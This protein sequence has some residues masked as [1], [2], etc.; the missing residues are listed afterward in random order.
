M[1]AIARAV[2]LPAR[3]LAT[4]VE[5][6]RISPEN[7]MAIAIAYG[8]HP[9]GALVDTGYLDEQWA[10][11]IDPVR[12]LRSVTEDQ[13]ADEVLRR[14]KLGQ[15]HDALD[16]PIDRLAER[17]ARKSNTAGGDVHPVWDGVPDEA[18]AYGHDLMGGTP[19]DF[20]S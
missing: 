13:L 14:M 6:E 2:S 1:R 8:H 11:P 9:V 3:T 12:A 7:V 17:R 15:A 10:N 18:A 4:Q 16:E 20:D 19:D 5:K